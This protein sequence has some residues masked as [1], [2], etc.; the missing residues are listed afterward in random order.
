MKGKGWLIAAFLGMGCLFVVC[1]GGGAA[2]FL[3]SRTTRTPPQPAPV[4]A[5]TPAPPE[6]APPAAPTEPAASPS[7]LVPMPAPGSGDEMTAP[8]TGSLEVQDFQFLDEGN[9]PKDGATYGKGQRI[10]FSYKLAGATLDAGSSWNILMH[11]T[12]TAPTG[13]VVLD[14]DLIDQPGKGDPIALS[15]SVDLSEES[16]LGTYEL[17][18]VTK[19]KLAGTEIVETY[20]VEVA[21]GE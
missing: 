5:T 18:V 21:A 2:Y 12:V 14:Q 6:E 17:R 13:Q 3:V 4:A 16:P 8:G 19:D 9:S 15:G 10:A 11:L 1:L 7:D 20:T